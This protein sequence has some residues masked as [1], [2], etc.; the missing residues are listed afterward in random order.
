MNV[1][2]TDRPAFVLAGHAA[3]FPLIHHGVNPP[4]QEHIT[5]ITPEEHGRSRR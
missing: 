4:N 5:S 1:T 3:Q 2:T